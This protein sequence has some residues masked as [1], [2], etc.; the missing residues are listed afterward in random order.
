[1]SPKMVGTVFILYSVSSFLWLLFSNVNNEYLGFQ[2]LHLVF[3]G[4]LF[5]VVYHQYSKKQKLIEVKHE[6]YQSLYESDQ[7]LIFLLDT[8]GHIVRMNTTVTKTVGV[9][10]QEIVGN[11]F[12]QYISEH[13]LE[14]VSHC[15]QEA[16]KGKI[17]EC[18]LEFI[19][20]N[21]KNFSGEVRCS[22][23]VLKGK[24]VSVV[25][26]LKDVSERTAVKKELQEIQRNFNLINENAS[27]MIAILDEHGKLMFTT[28]S[29]E[30][31]FG[32]K[33]EDYYGKYPLEA[34]GQPE[35]LQD[36]YL[37]YRHCIQ[38]NEKFYYSFMRECENGEF[39]YFESVGTPI[40]EEDSE[41]H[42]MVCVI[43][44][45]TERKKQEMLLYQTERLNMLGE[46]AAGIAHEL[47]NPI[48]S[49]RGFIQ[50][51]EAKEKDEK[52]KSHYKLVLDELNRLNEITNQ[53]LSYA[54]LKEHK[55]ELLQVEQVICD[56]IQLMNSEAGLHSV[57]LQHQVNE[58]EALVK[59]DSVQLKQVLINL[60]KNAIEASKAGDKIMIQTEKKETLYHIR[61]QDE[62]CGIEKERMVRLGEAFHTSKEGGTGLGLMISKRIIEDHG[63]TMEFDSVVGK[64]TTVDIALPILQEA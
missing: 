54:K 46:M 3:L 50:L 64:G 28:P 60:I 15:F 19:T 29:F 18:D 6:L 40:V 26:A 7:N 31:V 16:V 34:I 49:I 4:G 51:F 13:L 21:G 14:K 38:K 30:H 12:S 22:P 27:E 8:K 5:L 47:K 41:I 57:L 35:I 48:A 62:G 23:I 42:Q 45:V 52:N 32:V 9:D 11:H 55:K 20:R 33:P 59:G 37:L 36:A 43:R 24:V 1:M 58:Q 2:L 63:G 53:F 39:L 10:E 25:A 56:V 17:M 61:I 44:D